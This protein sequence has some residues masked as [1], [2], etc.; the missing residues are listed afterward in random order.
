M[1]SRVSKTMR[2]AIKSRHK[3][4]KANAC[5][6]CGWPKFMGI[7]TFPPDGLTNITDPLEG[8]VFQCIASEPEAI[9][10]ATA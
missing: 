1:N 2:D 4:Y 8:H 3:K 9:R 5:K 10:R 6:L 7:H